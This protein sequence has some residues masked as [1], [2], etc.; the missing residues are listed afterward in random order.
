MTEQDK[1]QRV[2]RQLLALLLDQESIKHLSE[3]QQSK[4]EVSRS[5]SPPWITDLF[6]LL[7]CW[8]EN[9]AHHYKQKE[10]KKNAENVSNQL[11]IPTV[12]NTLCDIQHEFAY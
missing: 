5:P 10:I 9:T 4:A 12:M 3:E 11:S 6:H 8:W 7:Q 1:D 2:L